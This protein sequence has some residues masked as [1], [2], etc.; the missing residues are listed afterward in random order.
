[1]Y[2]SIY[3]NSVTGLLF[4]LIPCLVV[5]YQ[6][7]NSKELKISY[8]SHD[9]VYGSVNSQNTFRQVIL[10][11][12]YRIEGISLFLATFD[13]LNTGQV[14]IL[15][16][17]Q[18][19]GKEIFNQFYDMATIADNSLL[20]IDLKRSPLNKDIKY[21]LIMSSEN[22]DKQNGITWWASE[23]DFYPFGESYQNNTMLTGDFSIQI[24]MNKFS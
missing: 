17:E 11:N 23:T 2:K 20:E 7:F 6:D 4:F 15:I 1:M 21:D 16:R 24:T 3:K 19:S 12:R 18:I 22:T 10:T 8:E 14:E 9:K 13:R 5:F